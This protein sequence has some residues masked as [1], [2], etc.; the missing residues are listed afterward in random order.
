MSTMELEYEV[1]ILTQRLAEL[2]KIVVQLANEVQRPSQAG[3]NESPTGAIS[4]HVPGNDQE[5]IAWMRTQGLVVEPPPAAIEYSR[6][7]RALSVA[8]RQT[9][10]WELDNMPTGTMVSELIAVGRE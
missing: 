10:Q 9:I 4:K 2:E 6:R 1:R 7:W 3:L 8:E 5:L